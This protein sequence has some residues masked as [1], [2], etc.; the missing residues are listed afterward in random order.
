MLEGRSRAQS[1]HSRRPKLINSLRGFLPRT[2][3]I[4]WTTPFTHYS[5]LRPP[6]RC[7][8]VNGS[9]FFLRGARLRWDVRAHQLASR[10]TPIRYLGVLASDEQ[11]CGVRGR[12]QPRARL[13]ATP[14]CCDQNAQ[15]VRC[16]NAAAWIR[17]ISPPRGRQSRSA[18][19]AG[20]RELM[21]GLSV[22][23]GLAESLRPELS[24][25]RRS[26]MLVLARLH[27]C[28]ALCQGMSQA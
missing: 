6:C 28:V 17:D 16:P 15:M 7:R 5:L 10:A 3:L 23:F 18:R 11:R 13:S 2:P 14:E 24:S 25:L 21:G 8:D 22:I 19:C 26:A 4:V 12:L 27:P 9:P 1:C 20:T